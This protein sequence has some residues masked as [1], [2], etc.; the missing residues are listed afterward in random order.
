MTKLVIRLNH[1]NSNENW[2]NFLAEMITFTLTSYELI[3][4]GG[5]RAKGKLIM[6]DNGDY[7]NFFDL[8]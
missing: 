2:V 7:L 3:S 6:S 1:V 5:K 8:F 4:T